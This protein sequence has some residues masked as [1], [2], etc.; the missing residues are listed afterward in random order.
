MSS[1]PPPGFLT[2]QAVLEK[3]W[4]L[5]MRMAAVGAFVLMVLMYLKVAS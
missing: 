4:N 2:F 1:P 3:T 5:V